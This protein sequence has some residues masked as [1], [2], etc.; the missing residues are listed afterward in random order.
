M[1]NPERTGGGAVQEI[2][3]YYLRYNLAQDIRRDDD[4]TIR[5][6]IRRESHP[7]M[8]LRMERAVSD[9]SAST[10][11][12]LLQTLQEPYGGHDYAGPDYHKLVSNALLRGAARSAVG[13]QPKFDGT[14]I[15]SDSELQ[16]L[17]CLGAE[18]DPF[19]LALNVLGGA[20]PHIPTTC[21]EESWWEPLM[22][23]YIIFYALSA[24]VLDCK[25]QDIGD[26]LVDYLLCSIKVIM[27]LLDTEV[28]QTH[29][30]EAES[31][32]RRIRTFTQIAESR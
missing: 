2:G 30:L 11:Q 28:A 9:V 18:E 7:T 23:R 17:E 3:S 29:P 13:K 25:D 15:R 1:A 22:H 32:S 10:S 27:E 14:M 6:T 31:L 4:N 5:A 8:P 26:D 19:G 16:L 21:H 12:I 20:S 24:K